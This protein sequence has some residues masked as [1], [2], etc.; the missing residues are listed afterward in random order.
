[1]TR[2]IPIAALLA[3]HICAILATPAAAQGASCTGDFNCSSPSAAT[4]PLEPTA[5]CKE[6]V[7]CVDSATVHSWPLDRWTTVRRVNRQTVAATK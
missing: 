6:D 1:M 7:I 2:I 4:W 5:A 3:F